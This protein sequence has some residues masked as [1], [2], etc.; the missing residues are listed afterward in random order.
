MTDQLTRQVAGGRDAF[1]E[2]AE[3]DRLL[4][5]MMRF[6][7]SHWAL[8]ER[9]MVLEKLLADNGVIESGAVEKYS[10]DAETDADWDARSF[11]FIQAIMEAQQNIES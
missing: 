11:A 4:A 9:V 6:M 1:F 7:T 10:P 2:N 3:S 8:Q 5:M